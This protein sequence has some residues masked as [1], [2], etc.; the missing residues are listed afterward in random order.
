MIEDPF[1]SRGRVP[2]IA[3][4]NAEVDFGGYEP[5]FLSYRVDTTPDILSR[6]TDAVMAIS[7]YAQELPDFQATLTVIVTWHEAGY[8]RA[9]PN[10]LQVVS[11]MG[12]A[13]YF[14]KKLYYG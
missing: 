1:P 2:L 6:A 5:G 12:N 13:A 7:V 3:P 8:F 14:S 9:I 11:L 4:F 10:D